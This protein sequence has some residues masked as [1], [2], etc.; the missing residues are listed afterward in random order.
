MNVIFFLPLL[1]SEAISK[2]KLTQTS[3][4]EMIDIIDGP[5]VFIAKN[6]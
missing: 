5:C 3:S 6:E 4:R 1:N 2:K